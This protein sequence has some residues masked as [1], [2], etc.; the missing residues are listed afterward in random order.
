MTSEE[1]YE[2]EEAPEEEAPKEA[3]P[4]TRLVIGL[5]PVRE[6]IR[7]HGEK[8]TRVLVEKGDSPTLA[9]VARFAKDRGI[10]VEVVDRGTLD[11]ATK[12]GRHQGVIAYCPRVTLLDIADVDHSCAIALDEI[13]DPQNFGAIVRSAVAL[14]ASAVI[15]PENHAAPLSPAMFRASAGAVEHASLCR[16]GALP[17]ALEALAARGAVIVG[18]DANAEQTLKD[19]FTELGDKPTVIVVGAEGKGL[20]KTV[21]R[22]CT[23]L[24]RLPMSGRIDSLNASVAAALA[25]Y[26]RKR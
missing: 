15:F 17:S 2:E 11:R 10:K 25:L 20:R 8:I 24:A 19:A 4:P 14:G 18:L 26:E 12:N 13:E 16:V 3:A 9:A 21:K 1:E 23:K 22:V 7:A 5:Q 6:A